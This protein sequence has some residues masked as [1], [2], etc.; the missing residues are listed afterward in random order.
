MGDLVRLLR[1]GSE[2]EGVMPFE[3]EL[4]PTLA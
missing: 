1:P 3:V 2:E 4:D